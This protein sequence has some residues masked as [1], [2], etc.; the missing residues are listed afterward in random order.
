MRIAIFD[1][2]RYDRAALNEANKQF[3]HKLE[4]FEDRLSRATVPLAAGFDAVECH[5]PF[6]TG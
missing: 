3:S 5:W 2:K 1:S 6:T 4:F